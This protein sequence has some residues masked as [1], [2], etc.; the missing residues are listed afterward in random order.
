MEL[1]TAA[2]PR[3]YAA[4][5]AMV[6]PTHGEGW[7]LPLMEA[8]AS[9]LPTIA[10]NWSGHLEYMNEH[11]SILIPLAGFV[12]AQG[13]DFE[14]GQMWATVDEIEVRKAM[15]WVV[16]HR[17]EAKKLGIEA[18]KYILKNF[19]VK[20]VTE[21]VL[22]RFYNIHQRINKLNSLGS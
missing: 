5:D 15:R 20:A 19:G 11:N 2:M 6:L 18:R 8:M 13:K 17:T 12:P 14:V 10:T 16:Q 7:G 22:R 3:L 4:M 21:R 1:D 9:G